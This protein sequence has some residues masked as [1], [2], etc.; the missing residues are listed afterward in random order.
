[1]ARRLTRRDFALGAAASGAVVTGTGYFGAARAATPPLKI[2]SLLPRSGFEAV[3]G[4]GCQ[5]AVDLA[6]RMLPE[7]G[8]AIEVVDADT[9]SKPDVARTQAEKLIREGAQILVGAFDSGQ[10]FAIAQ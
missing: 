7:S 6:K 3:I 5:R 4:Q 2:G 8:H 1:M 9:E 10:S